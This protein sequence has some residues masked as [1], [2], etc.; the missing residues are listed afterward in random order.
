MWCR[1][2][3]LALVPAAVS[4]AMVPP[5]PIV[6]LPVFD[7][8]VPSSTSPPEVTLMMP[9]LVSVVLLVCRS[10]VPPPLTAI[11]PP[12]DARSPSRTSPF[13]LDGNCA[14]VGQHRRRQIH[15]AAVAGCHI[16]AVGER[17]GDPEI[18]TSDGNAAL[19]DDAA[20]KRI[21]DESVLVAASHVDCQAA[22]QRQR[23]KGSKIEEVV[24]TNA[25][26]EGSNRISTLSVSHLPL[27]PIALDKRRT[28]F[29]QCPR[30]IKLRADEDQTRAAES[31]P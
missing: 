10:N 1:S 23:I 19:V 28:G 30:R 7:A 8:I 5:L 26:T 25:A 31:F 15:N 22:A 12:F 9:V 13:V 18:A 3:A 21:V 6:R 24:T 16:T 11:S 4:N 27:H 29:D 17:A 2:E 20:A 14:G